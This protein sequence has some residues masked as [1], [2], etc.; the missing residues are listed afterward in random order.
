MARVENNDNNETPAFDTREN[1]VA[2]KG[3][4]VKLAPDNDADANDTFQAQAR[5]LKETAVRYNPM[6]DPKYDTRA[7]AVAAGPDL[8][9]RP[10]ASMGQSLV[11]HELTHVVQQ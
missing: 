6:A 7:R 9:F 11:G 4:K 2:V 8:N 10:G 5:Q 3:R 1:A